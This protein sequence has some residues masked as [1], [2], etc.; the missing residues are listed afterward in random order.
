MPRL[1]LA[2]RYGQGFPRQGS[3]DKLKL[4]DVRIGVRNP[5]DE[6]K[7]GPDHAMV[8]EFG[9]SEKNLF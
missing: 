9:L 2:S 5:K 6:L 4:G 3:H 8:K 7:T 1:F